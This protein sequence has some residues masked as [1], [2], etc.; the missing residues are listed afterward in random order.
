MPPRLIVTSCTMSAL[1][2]IGAWIKAVGAAMIRSAI[3]TAYAILWG[4]KCIRAIHCTVMLLL[5]FSAP[6]RFRIAH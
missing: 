2:D 6:K 3:F 5:S 1:S 4:L